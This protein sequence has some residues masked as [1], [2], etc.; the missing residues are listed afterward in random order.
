MDGDA[1]STIRPHIRSEL[2]GS[3]NFEVFLFL[4]IL[5]VA[6]IREDTSKYRDGITC[7]DLICT[8]YV[9]ELHHRLEDPNTKWD[10]SRK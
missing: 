7:Q 10:W 1:M 4:L 2:G 9:D 3:S 5:H 6:V 8:S